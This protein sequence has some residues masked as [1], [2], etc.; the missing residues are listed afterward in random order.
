MTKHTLTDMRCPVCG[1]NFVPAALH[2]YT[3]DSK[4]FCSWGCYNKYLTE[5]E[6]KKR[7]YNSEARRKK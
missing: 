4:T 2:I 1:R 7:Q 6:L 5:Q 3:K